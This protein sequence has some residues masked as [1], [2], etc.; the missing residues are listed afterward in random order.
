[1]AWPTRAPRLFLWSAFFPVRRIVVGNSSFFLDYSLGWESFVFFSKEGVDE[2][3]WP[4]DER[5][6]RRSCRLPEATS[7]ARVGPEL[8]GLFVD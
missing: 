6:R 4:D 2:W 5:T 7:L 3:R 1:M 8:L